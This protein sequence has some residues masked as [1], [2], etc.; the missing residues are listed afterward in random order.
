[1][2]NERILCRKESLL[3]F[4]YDTILVNFYRCFPRKEMRLWSEEADSCYESLYYDTPYLLCWGESE[5]TRALL[6]SYTCHSLIIAHA[7][8]ECITSNKSFHD[9]AA[10]WYLVILVS[11]MIIRLRS[12]WRNYSWWKSP[13]H[14]SS[15]S[16]LDFRNLMWAWHAFIMRHSPLVSG[17]CSHNPHW[18]GLLTLNIMTRP[19]LPSM[20]CLLPGYPLSCYGTNSICVLTM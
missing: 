15:S 5:T 4:R 14:L 20:L 19:S 18:N 8:S 16:F 3:I 2:R 10:L 6:L 9:R 17:S 12:V 13:W 1:M 11:R 7:C